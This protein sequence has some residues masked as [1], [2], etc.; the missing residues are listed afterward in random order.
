MDTASPRAVQAGALAAPSRAILEWLS[1]VS[2]GHVDH[3][4]CF[5]ERRIPHAV[6][7]ALPDGVI[8]VWTRPVGSGP[9]DA[10]LDLLD[11]GERTRWERFRFADDRRIYASAHALLRRALSAHAPRDPRD[12]RFVAGPW[13]RPELAPGQGADGLRFNLTHCRGL[14]AC[15]IARGRL[16]GIDAEA[17]DRP[18]DHGELAAAVFT[19][20]ERRQLEAAS[21]G[22]RAETFFALWTLKEAYVK[23]RGLGLSLS[24][25]AFAVQADPPAITPAA[26]DP[27]LWFAALARPTP[28]HLMAL[29]APRTAG[30]LDL[31]WRAAAAD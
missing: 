28:R 13:G 14:V 6:T 1:V 12:W 2:P 20:A 3:D 4:P 24:L 27:D 19:P 26:D 22:R 10:G 23:A 11:A 30:P 25:Q 8:E 29:A 9:D 7:A 15:A 21:G 31:R 18:L 5:G 16:V 17:L